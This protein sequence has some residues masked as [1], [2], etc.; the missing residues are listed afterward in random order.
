[1]SRRAGLRLLAFGLAALWCALFLRGENTEKSMVRA[2]LLEPSG[3]GWSAGLLYQFPEASADAAEVEAGI[4][5]VLAAGS[6]PQAALAQAEKKLPRRASYRLCDHL[7][8]GQGSGFAGVGEL[9]E[10]IR[11]LPGGRRSARVAV[12]GFPGE[13]LEEAA[14]E[15]AA[16]P[17]KLLELLEADPAAPRLY[18]S[19]NGLILPIFGLEFRSEPEPE[20]GE[21]T[22]QE[23]GLLLTEAGGK[24]LTEEQTEVALFLTGARKTCRVALD[25][26]P[27]ELTLLARSVEPEKDGFWLRLCCRRPPD[28][29]TLT[30]EETEGLEALCTD[31]VRLCWEQGMDLLRLGSVRALRDGIREEKSGL[32]T[33]NA[34]PQVRTD[35]RIF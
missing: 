7:L 29:R 32:T 21:L 13:R 28:S 33:K 27:V 22:R 17:G 4:R 25:T 11:T 18:G 24:R 12:L 5:F 1:M 34:C 8:L 10:L 20:T 26:D 3:S 15:D 14:T 23:E 19:R 9:E 6:T 30:D 2:L 35:V 31:T 16:L